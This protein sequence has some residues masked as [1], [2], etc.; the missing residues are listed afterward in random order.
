VGGDRWPFVIDA[1]LTKIRVDARIQVNSPAAAKRFALAHCGIAMCPNFM[2][3]D[4][5][6]SKELIPVLSAFMPAPLGIY[7]VY[8][9]N[10]HLSPKVR[11]FSD[12]AAQEL[13][14][15]I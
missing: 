8:P 1:E 13:D 3:E 5:L 4:E 9:S 15:R 10:K 2:V 7:V 14:S 12:H 6:K 11:A